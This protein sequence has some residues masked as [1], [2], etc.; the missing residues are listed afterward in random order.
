M[1]FERMKINIKNMARYG[2]DFNNAVTVFDDD[3]RV[4]AVDTRNDFCA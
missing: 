3:E 4:E 1:K 2:I